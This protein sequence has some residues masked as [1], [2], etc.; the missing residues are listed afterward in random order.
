MRLASIIALCGL[1]GLP[2]LAQQVCTP[3]KFQGAYA[4]QL[5]GNTTIGSEQR[6]VASI[7]RVVFDGRNAV[8][9]EVSVNFAGY[10]LGNPIT[11]AYDA[12][13]DC[14]IS[15]RLQ[16]T[17]GNWQHFNGTLT[18]DLLSGKFRQTD[19]GAAQDGTLQKVAKTCSV[20][21]LAAHY[22]FAI[23]GGTTPMVE[24]QVPQRIA[25]TGA[26][27]PDAAGALKLTVNGIA[28]SG[29]VTVDSDCIALMTLALPSGENIA[30][31]G[32]MVDGGKRILAIASDAGTTA[33][34]SFTARDLGLR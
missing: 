7:G 10:F 15:F 31:R 3:A 34:A 19:A 9:G 23:S 25:V 13:A 16:D 29:T 24:G 30:L 33:S 26:A 2:A 21:A 22:G 18:P 12:Q 27:D 6:P 28:G 14:R 11:G 17:S 32:V 8:S 4:F 20:A 1:A 5:L